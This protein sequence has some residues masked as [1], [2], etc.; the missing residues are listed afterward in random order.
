MITTDSWFIQPFYNVIYEDG[1][2][3]I[4]SSS[5]IKRG[6]ALTQKADKH[7]YL[8]STINNKSTYI[9]AIVTQH[10]LG[11]RPD[12]FTVNHK[13]GVKI[14]N[15]IENLE[16]IS[17]GDNT[18][19]SFAMGLNGAYKDG[20][21]KDIKAYNKSYHLANRDSLN[22]KYRAYYLANKDKILIKKRAYNL[23]NKEAISITN[24]AHYLAQKN[25]TTVTTN[26]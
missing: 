16:Y 20:R 9:H 17:S 19:H 8:R 14:N 18:R 12:K 5:R 11:T 26:E 4:L 22:A 25:K 13:D 10:F 6:Q 24:K 1:K 7:G 3:T 21:C 2:V 15:K 23:A